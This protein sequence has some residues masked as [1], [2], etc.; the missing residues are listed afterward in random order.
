MR[1]FPLASLTLARLK[2]PN[3]TNGDAVLYGSLQALQK[4]A[5]EQSPSR[6]RHN[7]IV[8][9]TDGVEVPH[10]TASR[11]FAT[12]TPPISGA[13]SPADTTSCTSSTAQ[14]YRPALE[15]AAP[16]DAELW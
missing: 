12:Q 15:P 16:D 13:T 5:L 7:S 2:N 1:D 14:H 10:M 4:A 8:I 11:S 3:S 9:V 6:V